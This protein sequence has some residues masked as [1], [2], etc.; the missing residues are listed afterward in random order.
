MIITEILTGIR[1]WAV[2]KFELLSNKVTTLTENSTDTQFPSAKAVYDHEPNLAKLAEDIASWSERDSLT[3]ES[4]MEDSIRTTAGSES[5]D[6]SKGALLV[7]IEATKDFY[8]AS[9]ITTGF[10]LLRRAVAVGGGYYFPVPKLTF[11][12]FGTA[13]EPNGVLFTNSSGTN[14]TPT[15]Y[16]KPLSSGVP[17]STTDGT[18]CAYTDSNGYRFYTTTQAGYI[19]VSGITFAETCAHLGWSRRYDEYVSPTANGDAGSEISLTAIISALHGTPNKMLVVGSGSTIIAD[20]VVFGTSAATWYRKVGYVQPTW[21]TT[22]DSVEE[23]AAQTYTHT[24]T[25]SGMKSDGQAEFENDNTVLI[26]GGTTISYQD[27]S[28]TA[29]SDYVKYELASV[30]TG[31]VSISPSLTIEDW[32]VEE[33][34][35][36]TGSA[37]VTLQYAQNYVDALALIAQYKVGKIAEDVENNVAKIDTLEEE[38]TDAP[39]EADFNSYPKLCGQPMKLYCNGTP[40]SSLRPDNW[41][42]LADGGYDWNGAPSAIGQECIDYSTTPGSKYEAVRSGS[43]GLKWLKV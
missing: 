28:A 5:V 22:A 29:S 25:I 37:V 6:S 19:I 15:V 43:W 17:T 2:G 3:V 9:F 33:L 18:S 1:D 34:I 40:S 41:I 27:E 26:I 32:G 42:Q 11:G 7:S 10:N 31:T 38:V 4:E 23:G 21:T 39:T 20:K 8:A 30:T 14:L 16:F 12:T 13:N 24:A 35:D 36:C